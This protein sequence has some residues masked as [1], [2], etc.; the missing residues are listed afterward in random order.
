MPLEMENKTVFLSGGTPGVGKAMVVRLGE[1][2]SKN[3]CGSR[4]IHLRVY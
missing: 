2:G 1:T 4:K 3:P